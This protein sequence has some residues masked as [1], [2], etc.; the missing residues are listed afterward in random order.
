MKCLQ[1][2]PGFIRNPDTYLHSASWSS[3][4][5]KTFLALREE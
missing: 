3:I 1:L 5:E 2:S 4:R